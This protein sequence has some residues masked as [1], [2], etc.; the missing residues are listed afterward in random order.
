M[1]LT[2][3]APWISRGILSCAAVVTRYS[4]AMPKFDCDSCG[5]CCKGHLLIECDEID[6]LREPR[7]IEADQHHRGKSVDQMVDEILNDCMGVLL[8]CGQRCQFLGED[9]RCGIYP[10]RP[11][12]CVGMEP[13]DDQCQFCRSVEGLPPLLPVETDVSS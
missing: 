6:V 1:C 4:E 3:A 11:N 10:T 8:N 9:N 12:C 13:G 5:A 2:Q 7:L